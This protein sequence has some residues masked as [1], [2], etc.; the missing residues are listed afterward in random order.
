MGKTTILQALALMTGNLPMSVVPM[1]NCNDIET[2][3]GFG[4]TYMHSQEGL[5]TTAL[6]SPTRPRPDGTQETVHQI[7]Q[8]LFLNE[9]DKSAAAVQNSV[10]RMLDD[11]RSFF[12]VY[13]QA[14]IDLSHV[15]VVADANDISKIQKPVLDRFDVIQVPPYTEEEKA[16][17][18]RR[19]VFPKALKKAN[20]E[21]SEV[22]VTKEAV[23]LIAS[24]IQTPG[25]R[26][27]NSISRRIIGNYLL[28]HS[29][30]KSTVHYT[31]EMVERF[32]PKVEF[33]KVNFVSQS[34]SVRS[35]VVCGSIAR[36][37]NVQCLLSHAS[38]SRVSVYGTNNPLLQQE[39]EAAVCCALRY[40]PDGSYDVK[41]QLFGLPEDVQAHGQLGFPAFVAVASAFYKRIAQGVFYGN[42]T[43]LGG[44]TCVNCD[45]PDAVMTYAD[46]CGERRVYTATGFSE[47][48]K[49]SHQASAVEVLDAGVALSLLFGASGL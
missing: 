37:V 35:A 17:I 23:A 39:I 27:L 40:L 36:A 42:T 21:R 2:F 5:L 26:E 30:R 12:D 1:S 8:V 29:W 11:N 4:R 45:D 44:M 38:A 46:E 32:L 49:G 41:L 3:V 47:R 22:S 43:L 14:T 20:V 16:V 48:L 34:G 25:V 7:S 19:Y 15:M 31:P 33:R 13:H 24:R 9:L 28:H 6:M 18:F 10:L